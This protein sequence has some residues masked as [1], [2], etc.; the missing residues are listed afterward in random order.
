MARMYAG[1]LGPLAF[2]TCLARGV[3]HAW[4]ADKALLVAW[5]S[6]LAFALV[7]AAVGWIGEWILE[8]E[9]RARMAARSE[10]AKPAASGSTGS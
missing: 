3:V 9:V 8:D 1:I 10:A 6:L 7:G 2:V 4:P 5:A